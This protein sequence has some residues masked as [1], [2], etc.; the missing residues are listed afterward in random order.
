MPVPREPQSYHPRPM[1][2]AERFIGAARVVLATGSLVA[3]FLDPSSPAKYVAITY[4]LL[5]GYVIYSLGVLALLG[6]S[7]TVSPGW[8]MATHVFDLVCF[9][10][11]MYFTE[12]PTSPFFVYFIFAIVAATIRWHSRGALWTAMVAIAIFLLLGVYSRTT[13]D[14]GFEMNRFVIR[15]VYLVVGATLLHYLGRFHERR[16]AELDRIAAW[17]STVAAERHDVTTDV[18][19]QIAQ[20]IRAPRA[21]LLF[22][23]PEEPWINVVSYGD[24]SVSDRQDP[25][26]MET[27]EQ[28]LGTRSVAGRCVQRGDRFVLVT[29]ARP[30]LPL[31][32]RVARLLGNRPVVTCAIKGNGWRG[33]LFVECD[34]PT[35]D[36]LRLAEVVGVL[37]AARLDHMF[38]ME[39]LRDAAVNEERMRFARDLHDGLLQSL[40]AAALELKVAERL[41]EHD[42]EQAQSRLRDV[43]EILVSEQ[44]ELRA[45]IRQLKPET[46]G[47][48]QEFPLTEQLQQLAARVKRQWGIHVD[49]AIATDHVVPRALQ[50]DVYRLTHEALINA[51]RHAGATAVRA[52]IAR[53][54]DGLRISVE[55]DGRGFQFRGT[56]ELPD[57]FRLKTGPA[58]LKDRVTAL[59]GRLSVTSSDRGARVDIDLPLGA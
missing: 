19:A 33:R 21:V 55:D 41:L 40:A 42:A 28:T 36:E 11:F 24:G 17:A 26:V 5:S 3:V 59:G 52:Q 29:G 25:D 57:L 50:T 43:Q 53:E 46:G 6:R 39:R 9:G 58:T 30:S 4:G 23:E 22:E 47:E 54:G 1:A 27:L 44:R 7:T 13:S 20:V 45:F 38:L 35:A 31:D 15:G 18:M 37:A 2:R 56:Y 10:A 8:P 48:S 16:T 14:P 32:A 34:S 49:L 51:A 12:G